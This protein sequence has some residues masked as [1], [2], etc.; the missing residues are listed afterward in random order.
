[1][2]DKNTTELVF[3][4]VKNP[5]EYCEIPDTIR[6]GMKTEGMIMRIRKP[7]FAFT[8][9]LL[10]FTFQNCGKQFEVAYDDLASLEIPI[11][12]NGSNQTSSN[13]GTTTP[14][15]G[16]GSSSSNSNSSTSSGSSSSSSGGSSSSSSGSTPSTGTTTTTTSAPT[17]ADLWSGQASFYPYKKTVLPS[18]TY[19]YVHNPTQ[20]YVKDGV[21]YAVARGQ[22]H[23]KLSG[24]LL[25]E[26]AIV[27]SSTDK[28]QTWSVGQVI[29]E[30]QAG[31]SLC[32]F[33]DGTI[34]HNAAENRWYYLGQCLYNSTWHLCLYTR[35]GASP[36]GPW[37]A[38]PRNPVVK[39]GDLWGKICSQSGQ[40][41]SSVNDE[42]TP[43]II[44][45]DGSGYYYVTLHGH[46]N[47]AGYRGLVKTKD[48]VNW[49][50]NSSNIPRGPLYAASD[51]QNTIGG[52]IGGGYASMI[53]EGSYA[54]QA[55]EAP[56]VNLGCTGGQRWPFVLTRTT[57]LFSTQVSWETYNNSAFIE[58]SITAPGGCALQYANFIKD[59]NDIYMGISYFTPTGGW[60]PFGMYK[61]EWVSGTRKTVTDQTEL[62]K[63][64]FTRKAATPASL[65]PLVWSYSKFQHQLGKA[66]GTGW[67]VNTV[68]SPNTGYMIYGP[69]EKVNTGYT[70][71][72]FTILAD[73]VTADN[74]PLINIEIY[75][76]STQTILASRSITRREFSTAMKYQDFAVSVNFS[77]RSGSSIEARAYVH[78]RSYL[79]LM[80]VR[81]Q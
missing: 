74:L 70:Q 57:N 17:M 31:S 28:G 32:G 65:S 38:S 29:A 46:L 16:S 81:F 5:S 30:P 15:T 27:H 33:T 3:V 7:I 75:D 9:I 51:C 24:C 71:A 19:A 60:Y 12:V 22:Y 11:P 40:C 63:V 53:F 26:L 41:P 64:L 49:V 69:Y 23:N 2:V 39:G 8:F 80:S 55:I 73:N 21:W 79:N 47:G 76:A 36:M 78:G 59:G 56:T 45:I 66:E 25:S 50:V 4:F 48:F 43:Q 68:M 18:P 1:M 34:Y 72:V 14:S 37:T 20:V 67:A 61:L 35:D 6:R 42:G 62:S 77:G 10:V 13:T 52:C 44:A 58:N 54:Y